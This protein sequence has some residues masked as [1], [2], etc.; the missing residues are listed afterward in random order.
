MIIKIALIILAIE[1][2]L[3]ALIG[4]FRTLYYKYKAWKS[5]KFWERFYAERER[6]GYEPYNIDLSGME[7][8]DLSSALNFSNMFKDLTPDQAQE[9]QK[10][11]ELDYINALNERRNENDIQNRRCDQDA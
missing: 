5:K 4:T 7:N 10:K 2:V 11:I 3:I 9:F 1:A 8:W 6:Q